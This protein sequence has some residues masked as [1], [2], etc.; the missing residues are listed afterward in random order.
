MEAHLTLSLSHYPVLSFGTGSAV[1]LPGPSIDK[2]NIY[3][4]N[5]TTY[6]TMYRDLVTKDP[7]LYTANGLLGMLDR[8]RRIKPHPE[9]WQDYRPGL[10]RSDTH[11]IPDGV[12]DVVITC[13]ERCFDAVLEDLTNRNSP[14][15]RCVHVINVDIKDNHEEAIVGGKGILELAD[16]LTEAAREEKE[17]DGGSVDERVPEVLGRWQERWGNLPALWTV[18][19][20]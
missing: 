5:T 3:P 4:F 10:P 19:Y 12:V 9:R 18:G 2:P 17:N 15:N 14:L 7:R 1:R 13:E 8:N 6:D 16:M 20:F 11:Q